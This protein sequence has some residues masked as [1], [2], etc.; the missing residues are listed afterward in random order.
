MTPDIECVIMPRYK[1]PE[2]KSGYNCDVVI[3]IFEHCEFGT[4]AEPTPEGVKKS[5][6]HRFYF[7]D[8]I[9]NSPN[10][11]KLTGATKAD[12]E[13]ILALYPRYLPHKDSGRIFVH[14]YA[15]ISRSSAV[16]FALYCQSLGDGMEQ[17]AMAQTAA[18][19]PFKGIDPSNRIVRIADDILERGG[20][21]IKAVE[22]WKKDNFTISDDSPLIIL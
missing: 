7:D 6:H 3:S 18:S 20:K 14:C 19:A 15:G 17:A 21:M 1:L 11:R 12:I 9:D 13:Q 4:A 8:Q 10:H 5:L 22:D 16:V 2:A